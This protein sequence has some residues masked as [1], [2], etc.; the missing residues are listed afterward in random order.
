MPRFPVS[1]P[2]YALAFVLITACGEDHDDGN[3]DPIAEACEHLAGA[4]ISVTATSTATGAPVIAADH[5]RYDVKLVDGGA[6][7]KSGVVTFN[8]A[9]VG[10]LQLFLTADVPVTAAT[11]VGVP[12]T[13]SKVTIAPPCAELKAVYEFNVTVGRYDLTIGGATTTADTV[14]VVVEA[15]MH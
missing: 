1:L 5:K 8:S 15:D 2:S 12:V 10:H 7:G 14:G 6:A 9:A 3:E 11:A 13:G 4:A